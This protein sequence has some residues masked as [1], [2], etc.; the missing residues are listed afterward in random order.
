MAGPSVL[1]DKDGGQWGRMG[2]KHCLLVQGIFPGKFTDSGIG[3][4]ADGDSDDW[5]ISSRRWHDLIF[6]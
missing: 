1:G 5:K 3:F 6:I 4:V 2:Y